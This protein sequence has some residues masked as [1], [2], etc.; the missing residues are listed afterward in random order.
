MGKKRIYKVASVAWIVRH[1]GSPFD[2]VEFGTTSVVSKASSAW[3]NVG[4]VLRTVFSHKNLHWFITSR[5]H[6]DCGWKPQNKFPIFH[7]RFDKKTDYAK[8]V[9]SQNPLY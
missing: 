6:S 5:W 2:E 7:H 3:I 9:Y 1:C 4:C 8:S